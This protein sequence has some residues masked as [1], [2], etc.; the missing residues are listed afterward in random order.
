M[1]FSKPDSNYSVS[2]KLNE[3]IIVSKAKIL[4]ISDAFADCPDASI[5]DSGTMNKKIRYDWLV[6]ICEPRALSYR[7]WQIQRR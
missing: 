4:Y 5:Y 2:E 6:A 7:G 3:L 1:S